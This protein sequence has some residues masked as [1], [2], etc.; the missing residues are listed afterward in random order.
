MEFNKVING[1]VKYINKEMM[2]NL[3]SWQEILAR[4]SMSRVLGNSAS[5]K[6]WLIENPFIKTFAIINDEGNVDVDGLIEDLK[7]IVRE[8]GSIEIDIPLFGKFKFNE[9]DINILN[10]YIRGS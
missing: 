5:I 10:S 4:V 3:N 7:T 6:T 1:I 2:C 8:K 9:N